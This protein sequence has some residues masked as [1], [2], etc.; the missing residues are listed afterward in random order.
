MRIS[1]TQLTEWAQDPHKLGMGLFLVSE[2]T[3][4]GFL[5]IAYVYFHNWVSS[6]PT[7]ANSLDALRTGIYTVFL[8]ASSFTIWRAERYLKCQQT[9][10]FK[11]WLALTVLLGAV[12]L[13]GQGSEYARLYSRNVRVSSNVFGTSFFT[14]TGFHGLHVLLGVIGL[15]VLLG[16]A[17]LDTFETSGD[18]AVGTMAMY[19]HFV[20]WIWLVIF[21][22]VYLWPLV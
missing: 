10:R 12:F 3:F 14:L 9:D 2:A 7:A 11:R 19:W 4:F 20:D 18:S 21:S 22:V 1:E 5:I 17:L 6:G 8:L 15:A 13:F 16:L